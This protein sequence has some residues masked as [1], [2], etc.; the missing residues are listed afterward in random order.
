[1]LYLVEYGHILAAD[2]DEP[3]KMQILILQKDTVFTY[4]IDIYIVHR[5]VN[6]TRVL[7]KS[8]LAITINY[9]CT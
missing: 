2:K 8:N 9:R 4:H 3:N 6:R 1:M 7:I 5:N